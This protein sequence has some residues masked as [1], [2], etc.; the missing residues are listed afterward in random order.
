MEKS[1]GDFYSVLFSHLTEG[2]PP[3]PLTRSLRLFMP[4]SPPGPPSL[5][6]SSRSINPPMFIWKQSS[7]GRQIAP[8]T[9][10]GLPPSSRNLFHS[11]TPPRQ[12]PPPPP[13]LFM[14]DQALQASQVYWCCGVSLSLYIFCLNCQNCRFFPSCFFSL[15]LLVQM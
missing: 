12:T 1:Y 10:E 4:C 5:P 14:I 8:R 15:S 7:L 3:R 11:S 9:S 6:R 2:L 13:H